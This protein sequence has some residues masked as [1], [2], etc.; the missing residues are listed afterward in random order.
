MSEDKEQKQKHI[1]TMSFESYPDPDGKGNDTILGCL[2]GYLEKEE[3]EKIL[4]DFCVKYG[5]NPIN[6]KMWTKDELTRE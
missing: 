3:A 4:H 6:I 1:G 2:E 5:V